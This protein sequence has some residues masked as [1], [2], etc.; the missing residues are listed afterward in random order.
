MKHF[1]LSLTML[2][3][4]TYCNGQS[5]SSRQYPET[6]LGWKLG[7]VSYNF[8]NFTF[9]EAIDKFD[10]CKLIYIEGFPGHV[11]GEG[12]EGKLDYHMNEAT[13]KQ[14]L[15]RLKK[16]G[17]V[18]AAYG[19]VTPK[20]EADWRQLFEFGKAMGIKT[21]TSE[22]DE[23]D[24]PLISKLCDEYQINVAIHNHSYPTHYWSPDIVLKA[25]QGQ[26]K[27][28]GACADI[29]HWVESGLDPIECLKKLEG[30]VLHSHLADLNEKNNKEA[31]SVPWGT[32][33]VDIAGII[34]ELKR[35]HFNGQ[36]SAEYEYNWYNSVPDI[37]AGVIYFRKI[38]ARP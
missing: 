12:V 26:S 10:S 35:Q 14:V 4:V 16:K 22:P 19:V 21:F 18:M 30:H 25:I 9:W 2:A 29:A 34:K 33:V 7:A 13:R 15:Q 27:R 23:K 37:K 5:S 28:L 20:S 32:G 8:K 17:A 1:V 36:I 31:R 24:L 38:I 3:I 6:K 11:I